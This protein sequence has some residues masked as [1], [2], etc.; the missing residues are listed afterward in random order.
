LSFASK[1]AVEPFFFGESSTALFGCYHRPLQGP[2]REYGV[3][4]CAPIGREYIQSH[5]LFYQL[6]VQLAQLGFHVLRFDYFGC[7][8]S[9]GDFEKGS[10]RQWTRDIQTA[11]DAL[12]QRSDQIRVSLLGMRLGATLA[13]MAAADNPLLDDLVLWEP[14]LDGQRYVA[15][16]AEMQK[17]FSRQFKCKKDGGPIEEAVGFRLTARLRNDLEAIHTDSLRLGPEV[18]LLTVT[19]QPQDKNDHSLDHFLRGHPNSEHRMIADHR[20]WYEELYKRLIPV[21]TMNFLVNWIDKA[22]P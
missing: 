5:R 14:V 11:A 12:T 7:G 22:H 3:V 10:L 18:R 13:M 21:E 15:E 9:A 20:A 19:N 2:A 4:F 16:L 17:A 6:A 1:Y 8:D